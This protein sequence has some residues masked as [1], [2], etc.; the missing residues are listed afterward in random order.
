MKLKKDFVL[1]Q[2]ADTWIVVPVGQAV[3]DFN[4]MLTLNESG[5]LLW[6]ALEEETDQD[7]LVKV[8]TTEYDVPEDVAKADILGFLEKRPKAGCLES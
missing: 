2:V 4:C 3:L 6:N 7:A 5:A 1:R 8:M